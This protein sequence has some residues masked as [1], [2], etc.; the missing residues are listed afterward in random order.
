MKTAVFVLLIYI[1]EMVCLIS[2]VALQCWLVSISCYWLQWERPG[3]WPLPHTLC[4]GG[5]GH[6]LP[7]AGKTKR[8]QI[9]PSSCQ[10]RHSLLHLPF[11]CSPFFLLDFPL[12]FFPA[13]GYSRCK[14]WGPLCWEA[15]SIESSCCSICHNVVLHV[16]PTDRNL[17]FLFLFSCFIQ[18]IFSSSLVIFKDNRT[19]IMNSESDFYF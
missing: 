10:V 5:T 9:V 16:L 18:L 11:V 17:A 12:L 1:A 2:P 6:S 4:Y 7:A 14:N 13:L 15:R 3:T 8:C 19:Y